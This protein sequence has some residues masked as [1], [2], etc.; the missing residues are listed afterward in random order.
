[1]QPN[2]T[3]A[4]GHP[5]PG[6]QEIRQLE[7]PPEVAALAKEYCR[8]LGRRGAREI[9]H[10]EDDFKLQYYYGGREILYLDTPGGRV[11][12]A[13]GTPC[14]ENVRGVKDALPPE[15]RRRAIF[16]VPDLWGDTDI[17]CVS[18]EFYEDEDPVD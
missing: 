14:L 9:R 16:Y 13:A 6:R 7:T 11:I 17:Y 8:Q 1:M 2:G 10:V 12:V 15:E 4:P 18:P 3:P 5:P